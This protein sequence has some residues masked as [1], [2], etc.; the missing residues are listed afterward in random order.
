MS[1]WSPNGTEIAFSCID[2]SA[3][4]GSD[5][6]EICVVNVASKQVRTLTSSSDG[7]IGY[8]PAWSPNGDVIVYSAAH[9]ERVNGQDEPRLD[10]FAVAPGGGPSTILTPG[11][12]QESEP[13]FSP[14][15]T[16]LAFTMVSATS[17]GPRGIG[18]AGA[19]GGVGTLVTTTNGDRHPAWSPDGTK[20]AFSHPVTTPSANPPIMQIMVLDMT[21]RQNPPL[22]ITQAP[23]DCLHPDWGRS[24]PGR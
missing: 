5:G 23:Y 13:D 19:G 11:A 10:L 17:G 6:Q 7:F 12:D 14:D 2:P 20:L 9:L 8:E 24:Q 18:I 3:P 15:G 1:S 22:Q 4:E 16:Q 21:Q